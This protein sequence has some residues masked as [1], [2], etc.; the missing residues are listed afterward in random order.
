MMTI[1]AEEAQNN[2]DALLDAVQHESIA[3]TQNGQV[4][5]MMLAPP[6]VQDAIGNPLQ[7]TAEAFEAWSQRGQRPVRCLPQPN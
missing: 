5:A 1:T 3:I 2:L 7:S 6:V 4:V